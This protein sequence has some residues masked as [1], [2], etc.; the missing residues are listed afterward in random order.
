[1]F[2]N[3]KLVWGICFITRWIENANAWLIYKKAESSYFIE[4]RKLKATQTLNIL[5]KSKFGK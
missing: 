5:V 2:L 4:N 3:F 1:M